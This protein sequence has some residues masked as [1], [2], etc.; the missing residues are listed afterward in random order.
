MGKGEVL[1]EFEAVVLLAVLRVGGPAHAASAHRE[2]QETT[3]RDVSIATVH[4]TLNRLVS[5][6]YVTVRIDSEGAG[7]PRKVFTLLPVGAAQL[8]RQR[9]QFDA[10]WDGVELP[11]A[12]S[13]AP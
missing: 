7:R 1:G 13:E 11:G 3:G 10:L 2:I 8:D 9:R 6:G 5:K 12:P 4:V